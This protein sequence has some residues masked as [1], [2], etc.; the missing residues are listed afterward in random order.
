MEEIWKDVKGFEGYY[1]V[2]NMGRVRSVDRGV[3]Y[4]NGTI[5]HHKSRI[6]K[7]SPNYQGYLQVNLLRGG[8]A[9]HI[10]IHR[11]VALHFVD[12][13][14]DG[15]QINHKDENKL[16]NIADNLE[17]CTEDYNQKYGTGRLR[18]TESYKRGEYVKRCKVLVVYKDGVKIGEYNGYK[19]VG[20]ALGFTV[21]YVSQI[22]NGR[23]HKHY[24]IEQKRLRSYQVKQYRDGELVS[25]FPSI[26]EA[27]KATG[28]S[29]Y[30]IRYYANKSK[31]FNGILWKINR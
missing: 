22:A 10:S 25:R 27:S 12:G 4:S 7:G 11:L 18:R 5:H 30:M 28:V 19:E 2:S 20:D 1:Q 17:W 9:K 14:A 26:T 6:L 24:K 31:P 15:L 23:K 8:K 3:A 29:D 13:Y 21:D 16:N